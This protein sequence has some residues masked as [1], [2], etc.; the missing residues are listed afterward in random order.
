MRELYLMRK[1]WEQRSARFR[2]FAETKHPHSS[3]WNWMQNGSFVKGRWVAAERGSGPYGPVTHI[4]GS[5][6]KIAYLYWRRYEYT[7]DREWLRKR[8]YPMLKGAAEFYRNFPN[9]RKGDDGRYHIEHVNS[10]ESVWGARDTDEDLSAMRGVFAALLRAAE[11]LD[12]DA[13][14][15]PVWREFLEHLAPLPTTDDA[16]ALKPEGYA[17]PR[18]FVRGRKP[19]VQARGFLPDGNSL[20]MWFFDLCQVESRDRRLVETANNTLN[21]SFRSGLTERTP[22]GVL[23]KIGIAAASLGRADAV[24]ILTPNQ[25]ETLAPERGTAYRG[26]AVL[27]NRMTLRE[28]PQALDAERLGRAA[29]ALHLALLQSNPPA[30]GEDPILHVFP[31]WPREWDAEYKLR[32]RGAFVVSAAMERGRVRFVELLSEAGAACRLRN[33]WGESRV[34]LSRDGR[35]AETLAGSLLLFGTRRGERILAEPV[36]AKP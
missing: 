34:S 19:A 29:E 28:G 4:L 18:V 1:P 17:G 2:E 7:L 16:D 15:R 23:S 26:G 35:K 24:R 3:R 30:P 20:P 33:P 21:A 12:A 25:I 31:A 32:A 6:A 5:T 13:A 22:V 9:V 11:I 14:M 36:E 27:A 8:A 10:N